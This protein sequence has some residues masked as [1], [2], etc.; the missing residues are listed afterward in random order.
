[1]II[2]TMTIRSRPSHSV[3]P[4]SPLPAALKEGI[5]IFSADQGDKPPLKPHIILTHYAR[6]P[7]ANHLI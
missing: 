5:Q 4:G 7:N 6:L 3:W 2:V 1:M